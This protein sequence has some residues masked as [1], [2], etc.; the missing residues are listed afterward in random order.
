MK[1]EQQ[2]QQLKKSIKKYILKKLQLY[3][4]TYTSAHNNNQVT[5]VVA[6]VLNE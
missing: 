3:I 6:L 5:A 4:C 1:Q 2:Q